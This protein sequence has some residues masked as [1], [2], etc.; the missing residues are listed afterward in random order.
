MGLPG[1][2]QNHRGGYYSDCP[3]DYCGDYSLRLQGLLRENSVGARS[4]PPHA[5]AHARAARSHKQRSERGGESARTLRWR[6]SPLPVCT[7]TRRKPPDDSRSRSTARCRRKRRARPNQAGTSATRSLPQPPS[8]QPFSASLRLPQ[9]SLPQPPSAG[10][11]LAPRDVLVWVCA[12]AFPAA[13]GVGLLALALA[14]LLPSQPTELRRKPSFG[15]LGQSAR[16]ARDC[17]GGS[18]VAGV[19]WR[20]CP[21]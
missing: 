12:A 20:E 10:W 2:R 3:R 5:R 17:R 21:R 6:C 18:L 14:L 15:H 7:F 16:P 8:A 9:Q 4:T 19:S 1:R 11:R 13:E